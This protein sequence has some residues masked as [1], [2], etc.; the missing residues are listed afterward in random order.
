MIQTS[1]DIRNDAGT[2][3]SRATKWRRTTPNVSTRRTALVVAGC[4]ATSVAVSVLGLGSAAG[5]VQA[6][7][8]T[9]SSGTTLCVGSAA[10]C[11]PTL[12]AAVR[13]ATDGDTINIAEGT[14]A[15]GVTINKSLRVVGA[16]AH[17]TVIRGGGPVLTIGKAEA[18]SEPTVS[19]S[20]LTITGGRSHGDGVVAFGGGIYVPS[21]K[22]FTVGATVDVGN[23][24]VTGNRAAATETSPSPSG[25]KCPH[26]RQCPFALSAGGGIA[27][28]GTMSLHDSIVSDNRVAG[29]ASDAIGGGVFST[30]GDLSVN[31]VRVQRNRAMATLPN[32][33]F[34]EGGG[35]FVPGGRLSI[36]NSHINGN[37][38]LMRSS[39]PAK[40]GG[41][42]IQMS[43]NSGGVHVG[44]GVARTFVGHTVIRR[45]VVRA[46]DL[47]GEPLAFD[48]GMLVGGGRL[49]MRHSVVSANKAV[50]TSGTVID[51]GGG[52]SALEVNGAGIIRH[53][54]IVNNPSI[55]R[56][57]EGS[58]QVSGGLAVLNFDGDPKLVVV[59]RS[60]ISG[61]TA[62][63]VSETGQ[64]AAYGGGILNNSLLKL[65]H[66]AVRDNRG[67]AVG[68]D[69]TAQ[70]AGI[71]NG[72]LYSG[73]PVKLTLRGSRI[74]GN[75][76]SGSAGAS[77]QGGGMYTTGPVTRTNTRIA[78]NT[79]DQC[80][81]CSAANV[82][83]PDRDSASTRNSQTL[84]PRSGYMADLL[85]AIG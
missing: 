1:V 38:A 30:L 57:P 24:I 20:E 59:R 13:A 79:P 76:L 36:R 70:G 3:S 80:F 5:P 4:L 68:P 69:A 51:V 27:N 25:V 56:S 2:P 84:R 12:R 55:A 71:W 61:N 46:T 37:V 8:S 31:H 48:A 21:G 23:V 28:F 81:G 40:A 7:M 44:G 85:G 34:A 53:T 60:V 33:R 39:L 43:A 74:V 72:V 49:V 10:R 11:Y 54:R 41:E 9:A 82:A 29:V 17:K 42:V 58:A 16:G 75:S 63:A 47:N 35:M 50:A 52:G 6:S 66:V 22:D 18:A 67:I 78:R 83:S 45:N 64:A 32:G 62:K 65:R 15:G 77:L 14:F 73:P 26:H 19:I